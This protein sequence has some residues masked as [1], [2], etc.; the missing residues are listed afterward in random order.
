MTKLTAAQER[1]RRSLAVQVKSE[2]GT[3]ESCRL[4]VDLTD[5]AEEDREI[6]EI[7]Q[8]DLIGFYEIDDNPTW[9]WE[10]LDYRRAEP[11]IQY[12][13]NV[14]P[15]GPGMY[16]S[17]GFGSKEAAKESALDGC[18]RVAVKMVEA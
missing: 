18:Y 14:Y 2:G 12:F 5:I 7:E 6:A 16:V 13:A 15:T 3:I 17:Q 10:K 9:E 4:V 11:K 1:A 8:Q